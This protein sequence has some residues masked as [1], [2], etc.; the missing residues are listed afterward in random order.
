MRSKRSTHAERVSESSRNRREREKQHLRETILKAAEELFL[1]VGYEAFSL[2][3]VA[4]RIGYSA[5]TIYLYFQDKDDLL[6][7]L[8]CE[9]LEQFGSDLEAAEASSDD[10]RRQ[11]EA[12]GRAYIAFGL[13]HPAH[14]RLMFMQRGDFLIKPLPGSDRLTVEA[15]GTIG[16]SVQRAM[17]QGLIPPGDPATTA[18]VLWAG[19]HGIVSLALAIPV[20]SSDQ[21]NAMVERFFQLSWEGLLPR[22]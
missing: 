22:D 14:Y 17:D 12:I 21:V 5:T 3:K 19:V 18:N 1:E 20:L 15:F 10:P 8:A 4:E 6:F 16:R 9:G 7:A 2:R 13:R 11:I